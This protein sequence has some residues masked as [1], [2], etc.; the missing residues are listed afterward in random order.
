MISVGAAM[1][2]E[3]DQVTCKGSFSLFMILKKNHLIVYGKEN[4]RVERGEGQVRVLLRFN[5]RQKSVKS[6]S[7]Q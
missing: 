1:N 5:F 6:G 4:Q 3:L 2:E 7:P